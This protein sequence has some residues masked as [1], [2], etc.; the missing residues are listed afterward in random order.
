MTSS[1]R[2]QIRRRIW[3]EQDTLCKVCN[4]PTQWFEGG[5]GA[6]PRNAATM[7][8]KWP[9]VVVCVEC[10]CLAEAGWEGAL[11]PLPIESA[12]PHEDYEDRA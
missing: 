4:R 12:P 7:P 2:R 10:V 9:L 8:H 3:I 1:E 5:S 6:P 11:S